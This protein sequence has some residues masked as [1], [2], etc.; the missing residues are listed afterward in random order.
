MQPGV[1]GLRSSVLALWEEDLRAV[2]EDRY[3]KLRRRAVGNQ[4]LV[5]ETT[6]SIVADIL[7]NDMRLVGV[8][9]RRLEGHDRPEE[10]YVVQHAE[11]PLEA[12]VREDEA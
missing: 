11:V 5:S 7:R 1:V 12:G 10:V 2:R 3:A 4:I 8:G 6:D 9:K